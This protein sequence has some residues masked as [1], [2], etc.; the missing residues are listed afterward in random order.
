VS[1]ALLPVQTA[2]GPLMVAVIPL[3]AVTVRLA[4]PEQFPLLTVTE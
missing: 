1:V 4:V 2:A 3:L